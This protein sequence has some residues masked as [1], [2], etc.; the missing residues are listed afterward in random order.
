M[1]SYCRRLGDKD[2][3]NSE[4]WFCEGSWLMRYLTDSRVGIDGNGCK[5]SQIDSW[6]FPYIAECSSDNVRNLAMNEDNRDRDIIT[7]YRAT[8][9]LFPTNFD[10]I[11]IKLVDY[12]R[13][14]VQRMKY[15]RLC[16][17]DVRLIYLGILEV[18]SYRN[19][20]SLEDVCTYLRIYQ[21]S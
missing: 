18:K 19:D 1:Q 3:N 2:I 16:I 5:K 6:K 4:K 12:H 14:T 20:S 7:V 8:E 21:T 9:M 11:S 15:L 13:L 17:G 10:P